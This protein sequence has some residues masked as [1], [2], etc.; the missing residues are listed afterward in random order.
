MK[1][2]TKYLQIEIAHDL[3]T[4]NAQN[5]NEENLNYRMQNK[6][7]NKL[8]SSLKNESKHCKEECD[9]MKEENENN[10]SKIKSMQKMDVDKNKILQQNESQKNEIFNFK[11]TISKMECNLSNL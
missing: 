6:E 11:Q 3:L 8:I 7:L 4:Q 5:L 1:M 2:S 9:K 10:L